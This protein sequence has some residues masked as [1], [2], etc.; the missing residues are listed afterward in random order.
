LKLQLKTNVIVTATLSALIVGISVQYV[1][2]YLLVPAKITFP[3]SVMMSILSFGLTRYY[4]ILEGGDMFYKYINK[5]S[6]DI[7]KTPFLNRDQN[8]SSVFDVIFILIYSV[9]LL[10]SILLSAP[11]LS[12]IY[13]SWLSIQV[14]DIVTLGT[15]ILLSF[16]LP[17]Y[18]IVLVLTKKYAINSLLK[19]LLAYLGSMLITGLT[20]YISAIYTDNNISEIKTPLIIVNLALLTLFIVYYRIY[21]IALAHNTNI[22]TKFS[23]CISIISN[24]VQ[25]VLRVN[26]SELTIF[27]SLLGLII[28]S[29]YYLYGGATIG[30]Q[31]DHQGR[32]IIFL[33]GHFRESV[34]PI[35]GD[36]IYTPLQSALLAGFTA[37]SG[38]PLVN[39]YASIAFLNMTAVFAFYYFCRE[40]FPVRTK[41]AAILASTLLVLCGG[42]GWMYLLYSTG[43]NPV[44]SEISSIS[45]FLQE[46]VKFSD[47]I[48]SANF[49]IAAYPDFSTGLIYIALPAGFLLLALIHFETK[50]K[51][52]YTIIISMVSL[53]GILFHDEFYI[54]IIVSSILPLVFN[55]RNKSSVYLA[56]LITFAFVYIIDIISPA[57]YFTTRE[58]LGVPLIYLN[59]LFVMITWA[60][61]EVQQNLK[62]HFNL[63]FTL[64]KIRK[65]LNPPNA[66]MMLIGKIILVWAVAYLT[67]LSFI[68]W[69]QLPS[70][71]IQAHTAGYNNPW[72]LYAPR[73]GLVGLFGLAYI[74]SYLFKKFEKE[75][76][77]FGVIVVIALVT[78]PYYFEHRFSK[79]V[80]VGMIG[81][82]SL[83]MFRLL[84]FLGNRFPI[85]NGITIALIILGAGLSTLM[86]IGYNAL[87]LETHDYANALGRR[88]FPSLQEM[89][90]LQFI[91]NKIYTDSN[92]YNV[93]SFP[94]QYDVRQGGIIT[95]LRSFSGLSY[96]KTAQSPLTLNSSTLDAFY[97]LLESSNTRYIIIPHDSIKDKIIPSPT[98][99]A[100]DNFQ[101]VY[102]D[103]KYLVLAV[104]T[105]SGPSA[106]AKNN[107]A[108]IS[109]DVK[110][111]S[112]VLAE[113]RD[114]D[115]NDTVDHKDGYY[116]TLSTL[117][118]SRVG[119]EVFLDD[120]YSVFSKKVVIIPYD[121]T[122]WDNAT[123]HK[124]IEYANKGG[125]LVIV[126]SDDIGRNGM[127][128]KVFPIEPI[129]NK[130]DNSTEYTG[131]AARL[132]EHSFLN[133]SGQVRN[134]EFKN[135]SDANLV[136]SYLNQDNKA[137][138]PF[139][140]EKTFPSN[141]K[142]VFI[143]AK[144]YYDAIKNNPKEY[145]ATLTNLSKLFGVNQDKTIS[146]N[147][148]GATKRFLGQVKIS[149]STSLN[150]SSIL[151]PNISSNSYPL[152][153]GNLSILDKSGNL[154]S[155]I[156]KIPLLSLKLNGQYEVTV[157]SKGKL[158]LP[159][160]VS[161]NGYIGISLPK[162]FNMTV[163]LTE[164]KNSK[165]E[166]VTS[167]GSHNSSLIATNGSTLKLYNVKSS[168]SSKSVP[169]LMKKP[170]ITVNGTMSFKDANFYGRGPDSYVPLKTVGTAKAKFDFVDRYSEPQ[171]NGTSSRYVTYLKSIDI[172]GVTDKDVE[173]K[174]PGDIPSNAKN[175]GLEIPLK[176]I[177]SSPANFMI[178]IV[179]TSATIII[180]KVF[181]SASLDK[182]RGTTTS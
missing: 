155:S 68:I 29:T 133:V 173:L 142:I 120:D 143:N 140:M 33:L 103:S 66:K 46:H 42:F 56:F 15:G 3:V 170:E 85:S 26:L 64:S 31:W 154:V 157:N 152:D 115:L 99:F 38:T 113:G 130:S 177:L 127:F 125:I 51:L 53:L 81:F 28:I 39:S 116:Y 41:R 30:D 36:I 89:N 182:A 55:M 100:M 67:A 101:P 106:D 181:W 153:V 74:L 5:T 118:L 6:K 47:I 124:Y 84:S 150:G 21:R 80:M 107:V 109:S 135:S 163:K 63:S 178:L 14:I 50:S 126:N 111:S 160:P 35:G 8:N 156:K 145:F 98:R 179:L 83:L 58:V 25:S 158:M 121:P 88:D 168:A 17:G 146:Q 136:A 73:L 59:I 92:T 167:D 180:S 20:T 48:L 132:N 75:V 7:S 110:S 19:I 18:A 87:V 43:V 4:S 62:K 40:W 72:Y 105:L 86:Y 134:A 108:I 2:S 45:S 147:I 52:T 96:A 23:D 176:D 166:I 137:I 71:Y 32:A 1:L 141:G 164:E 16:F 104:P 90:L 44:T 27:G 65:Q 76:F 94:D 54:F 60:L 69:I 95:K 13:V 122:N 148:I 78:G 102:N 171:D 159:S 172:H 34:T 82:A 79:Y 61:Y 11:N 129:D 162:G 131:I 174:L 138:A 112:P 57:K 144:G 97:H 22:Y 123:F 49:M 24:K 151:L 114:L 119:Y 139:I 91:R 12:S 70:N 77:V 128:S 175:K 93:A 37:L 9:S 165:A 169:I 10:I 149:G 117:A 161:Q